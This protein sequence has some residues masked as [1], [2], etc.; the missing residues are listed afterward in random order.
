M[1]NLTVINFKEKYFKNMAE[2][3]HPNILMYVH[4]AI[5]VHWPKLGNLSRKLKLIKLLLSKDG[6]LTIPGSQTLE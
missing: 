4:V 6:V 5:V 3:V 1:L 2:R